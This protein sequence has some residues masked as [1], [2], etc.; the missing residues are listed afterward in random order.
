MKL[1]SNKALLV[2]IV[3]S[4][5]YAQ[6]YGPS[7]FLLESTVQD[8]FLSQGLQSNIVA[9]IRGKVDKDDQSIFWKYFSRYFF[10]FN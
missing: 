10:W 7:R 1:S 4:C 8:T 6:H 5:L 3:T 9:E 2:F